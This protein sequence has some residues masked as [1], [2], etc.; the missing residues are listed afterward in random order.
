MTFPSLVPP[1]PSISDAPARW[2]Q[3]PSSSIPA[4]F[5]TLKKPSD[6]DVE[7]LALLN[8]TFRPQCEI[9]ALLPSE[10]NAYLPPTSWL[11][12]PTGSPLVSSPATEPIIR[13]LSNGRRAPD[14]N[15]FYTRAKE[16]FFKN[17]DAFSTLTRKARAGQVPL[18]LAHFRKFWEGLDNMAYYWDNTLDEYLPPKLGAATSAMEKPQYTGNRTDVVPPELDTNTGVELSSSLLSE[19]RKKPKTEESRTKD[20][21]TLPINSMGLGPTTSAITSSK[22]LPARSAP[23]RVPWAM[24]MPIVAEKPLDL[25]KGSYRGYRIGN[26]AEMPDQYRLDCTRAF[27]EPIAWAFGVTLVPHRRP[28]VLHMEHVRFPVRMNSVGWRSPTDRARARQGWMEGPVLGLQCRPETNF[29][30]TGNLEAESVL[31]LVRELGGMLLLAQERARQGKTEV[32]AG[33]GKWWTVTPRWGGGSGGDVGDALHTE[34]E[35]SPTTASPKSEISE[36][37]RT[38]TGR[39]RGSSTKDRKRPTPAEIWSVLR[40]G[41]PLWDPKI[42]YEAIGKDPTSEWDEVYLTLKASITLTFGYQSYILMPSTDLYG[43]FT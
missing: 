19:P 30:A 16:L 1:E 26:G 21:L 12:A 32:K 25:S 18:R 27:L 31:D 7:T 20:I 9:E 14:R 42:V 13:L 35:F 23:P 11:E 22:V 43:I 41:N 24:N 33:E 38:V 10:P 39:P 2:A 37:E 6:V 29:G 40:S 17:E 36:K 34:L 8:V 28:P 15:E 4:H 5:L 3:G